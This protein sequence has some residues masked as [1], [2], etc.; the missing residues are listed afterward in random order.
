MT[1]QWI[2]WEVPGR[3][4]AVLREA[5]HEFLRGVLPCREEPLS[6]AAGQPVKDLHG[7]G[8]GRA[9]AGTAPHQFRRPFPCPAARTLQH[10]I[11]HRDT[12]GILQGHGANHQF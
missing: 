6:P 5:G 4:S 9:P 7:T 8:A 3:H 10:R 11:H 12:R 2:F 1:C